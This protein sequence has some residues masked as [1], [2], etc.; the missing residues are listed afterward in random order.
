MNQLYYGDSL[1]AA[2]AFAYKQ[3]DRLR[4][5][6]EK[7]AILT[8][9]DNRAKI[10]DKKGADRGIDGIAY[11]AGGSVLFS[12]KSGSVSVKDIRDFRTVIERAKASAGIFITLEEPAKPMLQA[13][14]FGYLPVPEQVVKSAVKKKSDDKQQYL[15]I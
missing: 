2:R 15:T 5:E 7:R 3:D 12:G 6:F 10:N 13:A 9:T 11:I 8:Y 1:E 4:K 14:E